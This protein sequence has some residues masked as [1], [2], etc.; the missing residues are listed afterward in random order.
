MIFGATGFS[1]NWGSRGAK[2]AGLGNY[3]IF[4]PSAYYFALLQGRELIIFD[5]SFV[6]ELCR[7]IECGFR[8]Y[9]QVQAMNVNSSAAWSLKRSTWDV[10]THR[11]YERYSAGKD[12]KTT[13]VIAA[14]G[15]DDQTHWI[16][17]THQTNLFAS[18][19][20]GCG[21]HDFDCYSSRALQTLITGKVL[22]EDLIPEV[23]VNIRSAGSDEGH[24]KI[25][26]DPFILEILNNTISDGIGPKFDF[27]VHLRCQLT[28]FE[29]ESSSRS[30]SSLEKEVSSFMNSTIYKQVNQQIIHKI[31][32][33]AAMNST[34]YIAT[35]V[36]A[37]T[38]SIG[39]QLVNLGYRVSYSIYN[40]THSRLHSELSKLREEHV[41]KNG[42]GVPLSAINTFAIAL[43]WTNLAKSRTMLVWR[44]H[45]LKAMSTYARSAALSGCS[46]VWSLVYPGGLNDAKDTWALA[47]YGCR[48]IQSNMINMIPV[49][50]ASNMKDIIITTNS[51]AMIT[52]TS[53]RYQSS[54]FNSTEYTAN[55]KGI[56]SFKIT[57][58]TTNI[59]DINTITTTTTI[60][61]ST[62]NDSSHNAATN[63]SSF[64]ILSPSSS[65]A[66]TATAVAAPP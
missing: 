23:L 59:V 19:I 24:L 4:F 43:D 62:W 47:F 18:K 17:L 7:L 60:P 29:T 22:R 11:G 2:N 56:Q 57:K 39:T 51:S 61:D 65:A 5:D 34:V 50:E 38:T 36:Q 25:K 41:T 14:D 55:N 21:Y 44:N 45:Q 54:I 3:L 37:V 20:M 49:T 31:K 48:H 15:I 26:G 6:G 40:S 66:T 35:D 42:T 46:R 63:A 9:S 64:N 33:T 10:I 13:H 8:F 32:S 12:F 28:A 30:H 53:L 58:N 52:N 27:A 16:G 1:L